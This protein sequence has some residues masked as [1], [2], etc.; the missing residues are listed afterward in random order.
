WMAVAL[1]HHGDG[2][3]AARAYKK[4]RGRSRGRPRELIDH[5]LARLGELAEPR[6]TE[7]A[8]VAHA[9]VTRIEAAPLPPPI[10]VA[11]LPRLRATWLVTAL[12]LAVS[13]TTALALGETSDLGVLIRAG[14]LVRGL[15]A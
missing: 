10:R 3:G 15:V 13:A 7:L 6:H 4:A 5:A 14:A 12:L 9:V 2:A 11:R 1:D 8:A